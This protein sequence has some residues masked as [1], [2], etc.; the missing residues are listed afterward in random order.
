MIRCSIFVIFRY[1]GCTQFTE[2]ASK[3]LEK[4]RNNNAALASHS[5]LLDLLEAPQLM[6]TCVRNGNFDEALELQV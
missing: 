2:V 4:R 3:V 5:Q 1:S 6:D